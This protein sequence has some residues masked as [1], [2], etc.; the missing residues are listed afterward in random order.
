MADHVPY[1]C[2]KDH[3]KPRAGAEVWAPTS[4]LYCDDGL[5]V[6]TKCFAAEA[7]LA[8]EC[9]ERLL[10]YGEAH[11]VAHGHCD[12]VGGKWVWPRMAKRM[13]ADA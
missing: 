6:C 2:R 3:P 1:V 11:D 9:P 7:S 12:F 10:T 5:V 13:D 4:C 8:T